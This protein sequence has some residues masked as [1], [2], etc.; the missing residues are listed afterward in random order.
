MP[1]VHSS[2][3]IVL[4]TGN[5]FPFRRNSLQET[6]NCQRG[7]CKHYNAAKEHHLQKTI[8]MTCS[9]C[10]CYRGR[11]EHWHNTKPQHPSTKTFDS[12]EP[13]KKLKHQII[14]SLRGTLAF[15]P[16]PTQDNHTPDT[17]RFSILATHSLHPKRK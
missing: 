10:A 13:G 4:G 14:P 1:G 12:V 11:V 3:S 9:A 2:W 6:F 8:S 7:W 16:L 15:P 5:R 17:L